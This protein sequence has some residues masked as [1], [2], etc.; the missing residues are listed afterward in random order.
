MKSIVLKQTCA[1]VT[2]MY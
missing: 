1:K 2:Y